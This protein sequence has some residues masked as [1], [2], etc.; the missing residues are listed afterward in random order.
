MSARSSKSKKRARGNSVDGLVSGGA[1]PSSVSTGSADTLDGSQPIESADLPSSP[2][3]DEIA[4]SG[5]TSAVAQEIAEVPGNSGSP[6][7]PS[8]I[9]PVDGSS[10]SGPGDAPE[11]VSNAPI[12]VVDGAVSSEHLEVS[13]LLDLPSSLILKHAD[14]L[15]DDTAGR[16]RSLA[17]HVDHEEAVYAPRTIPSGLE[18]NSSSLKN[19]KLVLPGKS[20]PVSLLIVGRVTWNGMIARSMSNGSPG[21][22]YINIDPLVEGDLAKLRDLITRYSS[23]GSSADG[24]NSVRASRMMS[25]RE[26]NNPDMQAETFGRVYDARDG[27]VDVEEMPCLD[28]SFVM[29]HDVVLIEV[30]LG[31]FRDPKS[32]DWNKY[33]LSLELDAVYVLAQ[34]PQ[35]ASRG[36]TIICL[37]LFDRRLR[38][39]PGPDH[40]EGLVVV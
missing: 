37:T 14:S 10:S 5:G 31:R 18:W 26:R 40:V 29:Q 6:D 11:N 23:N 22:A 34:A 17:V 9:L 2:A 3:L 15:G 8:S 12:D 30:S 7:P 21:V 16:I 19:S 33:R 1:V 39:R 4:L 38:D 27:K 24:M 28:P 36:N 25:Y 35:G 20:T 32:K 13:G